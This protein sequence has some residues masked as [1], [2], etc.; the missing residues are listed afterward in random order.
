MSQRGEGGFWHWHF[1]FSLQ[2]I[3]IPGVW[4]G[5]ILPASPPSLPQ[6]DEEGLLSQGFSPFLITLPPGSL[7]RV[8]TPYCDHLQ[9]PSSFGLFSGEAKSSQFS[10]ISL[11]PASGPTPTLTLVRC[12]PVPF[13]YL[14]DK[15]SFFFFF[16][17]FP[18]RGGKILAADKGRAAH[19]TG[20]ATSKGS[21]PQTLFV[22]GPSQPQTLP[23]P[24]EYF[25]FQSHQ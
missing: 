1:F 24:L 16:F 5:S 11:L 15:S 22:L 4:G 6:E 10:P 23:S 12:K 9:T 3:P 7:N 2:N 17:N 20:E 14:L 8:T 13:S 18:S 21:C 25:G 19:L